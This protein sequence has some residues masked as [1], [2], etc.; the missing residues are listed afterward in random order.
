MLQDTDFY[1][2]GRNGVREIVTISDPSDPFPATVF[3]GVNIDAYLL[4]LERFSS[5]PSF[6]GQI[7]TKARDRDTLPAWSITDASTHSLT[8][9]SA[10]NNEN[11]VS[12]TIDARQAPSETHEP[13]PQV[14]IPTIAKY[15][16]LV[17][18]MVSDNSSQ[19]R[20]AA[21]E[22]STSTTLKTRRTYK[23][24]EILRDRQG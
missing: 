13:P 19:A 21:S 3:G 12:E 4:D 20:G 2:V 23:V 1:Q 17:E 11:I 15:V 5:D 10:P 6:G 7:P 9:N 14:P 16:D 22:L 8:V 24:I 18:V